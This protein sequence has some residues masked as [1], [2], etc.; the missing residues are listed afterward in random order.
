M[1]CQAGVVRR[2]GGRRLWVHQLVEALTFDPA[3]DI[4]GEES[5][6]GL[7]MSHVYVPWCDF[8]WVYYFVVPFSTL[9]WVVGLAHLFLRQALHR[10]GLL[11]PRPVDYAQVSPLFLHSCHPHLCQPSIAP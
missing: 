2:E 4:L 3:E 6:A 9:L 8:L 10:R 7:N 11:R 1:C 5:S